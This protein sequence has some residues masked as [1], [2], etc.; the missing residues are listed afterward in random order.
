M[1]YLLTIPGRLNNLNDFIKA[2]KASRYKGGDMKSSD[3]AIVILAIRKCLKG[4]RIEKQVE[5]EYLWVERNSRRDMDNISSWGR[6]VIQDALVHTH[7]LQNDGWKNIKGFSDS[8]L[9]DPDNPRIEVRIREV[10]N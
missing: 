1:E 5:M 2:D 9:V 3:E 7:V 4:V 10:V 8:F 6:K